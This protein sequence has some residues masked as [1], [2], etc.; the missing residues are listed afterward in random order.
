MKFATMS[1][2]RIALAVI[3][4]LFVAGGSA[5]KAT[6]AAA[7]TTSRG[8]NG[9]TIKVAG[10]GI[11]SQFA[12]ADVGTQA[13]FKRFNDTNEMPGIKIQYVDFA[14][15][16]D[17]PATALS[18]ARQLVTQDGVFAIVPDLS[19][20]N[21][22]SYF[23]SQQV[24]YIGWAIDATYCSPKPT[25]KLWGFGYSG[26]IVPTN[27]LVMPNSYASFYKYVSTKT[28]KTNPS[29][30]IFSSDNQS[31]T[32]SVKSLSVSL[33]GAGFKVVYKG[34]IPMVVS[35]YS[36]YIQ[37]WLTS[38]GGKQPDALDCLVNVQCTSVL[39]AV[40]AA[41]YKG[42]FYQTLGGVPALAKS[43]A[44]TLTSAYYNT[45]PN[46]GL[47]Q[48]EADLQAFKPGTVPIGYSNVPGYFAA[49]MFIKALK[50]VGRNHITPE[51]VQ[52]ALATQS[53]RIPGLVGPI[54]YP[55]ATA[56]SSPACS[57]LLYDDGTNYNVVSPYACSTKVFPVN[58]KA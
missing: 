4:L 26:C 54:N 43:M 42:T 55:A 48:M 9:S 36:P 1:K 38:N 32:S 33:K 37:Q 35:D 28:K 57:E 8:F 22:V 51:A 44:G 47:T 53:W 5:A 20:V 13:R 46:P 23:T 41:G 21:P 12:G 10:L 34:T 30:A 58:G 31:G 50:K 19:P 25:T 39:Q 45:Q 49:D 56:V 2:G 6:G 40:R 7:A 11:L 16:Q 24:P 52:K 27:P 14:D 15:D 3:A 29:V 18:E 17:N